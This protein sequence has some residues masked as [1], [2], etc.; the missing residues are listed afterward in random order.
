MGNRPVTGRGKADL[1]GVGLI[2]NIYAALQ[3]NQ[4]G[5]ACMNAAELI[6][7]TLK[8]G[9]GPVVIG[10]GFPEGGGA[11]ETDGPVGAALYARARLADETYL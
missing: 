2:K 10:T 9:K 3:K 5:P 8:N 4:P 7:E 6:A 11:P 1:T